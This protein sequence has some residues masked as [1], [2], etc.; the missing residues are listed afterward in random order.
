MR[1]A[2]IAVDIQ[3]DFCEG[4]ALPVTGGTAVAE[5]LAQ[6]MDLW[7]DSPSAAYTTIVA[8][9]D[10]HHDPGDHWSQDPDFRDSWPIHCAAGEHGSELHPALGTADFD[11]L[12]RK[13]AHD[14]AYSAF[15]GQTWEGIGLEE[16]LRDKR[17]TEVDVCGLATDHCVKATA[18]DARRLGFGT[19]VLLDY[20]AGVDPTTT[21]QAL[22]E[23]H[24]AGIALVTAHEQQ[25]AAAHRV[26]F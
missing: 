9:Q 17:V 1:R 6:M 14:A 8:S 16:W 26:T 10:W 22:Q 25:A 11:A 23:M 4:G 18:L 5:R 21:A 3:N 12:F 20:S 2:L 7:A 19:R 24:A 13:G 15:E